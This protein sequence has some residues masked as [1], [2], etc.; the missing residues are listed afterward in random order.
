MPQPTI[1]PDENKRAYVIVQDP[2]TRKSRQVTLYGVT[3]DQ[4]VKF[5]RDAVESQKQKNAA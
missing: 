5:I 4:A 2:Q 1:K 3:V